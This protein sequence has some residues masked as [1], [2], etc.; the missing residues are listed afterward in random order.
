MATYIIPEIG[1]RFGRLLVVAQ[2]PDDDGPRVEVLCDCGTRKAVRA[3][4]LFLAKRPTRSCGCSCKSGTFRSWDAM[5]QR[6]TNP[7]HAQYARYGGR[8]I[9]VCKPWLLFQE[10][11]ADMGDR[12]PGMSIERIDNNGDYEPRN[13]R[14]ATFEEQIANRRNTIMIDTPVGR[15][16]LIEAVRRSGLS[17]KC[18][19]R[20]I[21]RGWSADRLFDQP[22]PWHRRD[23]CSAP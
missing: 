18:L 5:V 20:R 13:C 3:Y 4:S 9:G 19:K 17:Y 10:F 6:C 8:G 15:M 11:L 16:P 23:R 1:Q 12:P 7:K 22:K 2:A 14:W 21:D